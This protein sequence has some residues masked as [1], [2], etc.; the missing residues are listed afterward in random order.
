[1]K[2]YYHL[3]KVDRAG[4]ITE[5]AKFT[6]PILGQVKTIEEQG[7]NNLKLLHLLCQN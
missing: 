7:K 3:I 6:Y 2:K 4:R 1:M 5:Q